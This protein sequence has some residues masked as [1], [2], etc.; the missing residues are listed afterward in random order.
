MTYCL[1]PFIC[2]RLDVRNL[3]SLFRFGGHKFKCSARAKQM[4]CCISI[5]LILRGYLFQSHTWILLDFFLVWFLNV[6]MR[7]HTFCIVL[8]IGCKWTNGLTSRSAFDNRISSCFEWT[9]YLLIFS[10]SN[11]IDISLLLCC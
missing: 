8:I 2:D 3:T 5:C 10:S 1:C 11:K 4:R 6:S 7:I 9:Q